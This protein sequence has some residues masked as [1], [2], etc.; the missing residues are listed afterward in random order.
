MII[1]RLKC[2]KNDRSE[3]ELCP[4]KKK[5]VKTGDMKP[6]FRFFVKK[7]LGFGSVPITTLFVTTILYATINTFFDL[8]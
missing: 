3:T 2:Y 1:M 8:C 4:R 5:R 6:R 7:T